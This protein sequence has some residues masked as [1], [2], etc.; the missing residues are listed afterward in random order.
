MVGL[1]DDD[2]FRLPLTQQDF[3]D[4]SGLST[5]P[6][7]RTIQELRRRDLIEWQGSIV[8]LLRRE[9]LE[10]VADFSPGYR[11]VLNASVALQAGI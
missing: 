3:A 11:H 10:T 7:N 9:E 2:S 8:R 6:V 5:V 4:A 1:L